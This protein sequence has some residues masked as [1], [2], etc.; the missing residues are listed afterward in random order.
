MVG[1]ISWIPILIIPKYRGLV[2]DF[3]IFAIFYWS[4]LAKSAWFSG[5]IYYQPGICSFT[6]LHLPKVGDFHGFVIGNPEKKEHR[7][8]ERTSYCKM[9]GLYNQVM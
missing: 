3:T 5:E 4:I 9:E 1:L 7:S 2:I 8:K 6:I